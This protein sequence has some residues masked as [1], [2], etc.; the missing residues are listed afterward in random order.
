MVMKATVTLLEKSIDVFKLGS[1][2]GLLWSHGKNVLAGFGDV[3]RLE[4]NSYSGL[5]ESLTFLKSIKP[6]VSSSM[7]PVAFSALP[8]NSSEANAI[9]VPQHCIRQFD[10]GR[11]YVISLTGSFWGEGPPWE[12]LANELLNE[13][14]QDSLDGVGSFSLQIKPSIDPEYWKSK[15]VEKAIAKIKTGELKKVV[16]AREMLVES[17]INF[18]L[19]SILSAL[20]HRN[21][22]SI[23]FLIDGFVGASPEMLISKTGD[24]VT[25]HPLAGTEPRTHDSEQD[26]VLAQQL[27]ES[28]KDQWE[29]RITID[30]FLDTLL[31]FC[32]FV[33]AEPEPTIVELENVFHLGTKVEG[34]LSSESIS[35]C[36]LVQ[37]LHPTPAVG[38]D[39]Q[40][41]A[42]KVIE[43]LEQSPRGRY[44]GPVGW[45]DAS[46]DG[47]FAVGIRSAEIVGKSARL[48]AGVGV[49]ADSDPE[50]ELLETEAK[51]SAMLS[52]LGL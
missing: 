29:H 3:H 11:Q 47:S 24:V 36:E 42:L 37:A 34:F 26:K 32:S 44:A 18:F 14:S 31:P 45:F 19:P 4:S 15:I 23:L 46:G 20:K 41:V 28:T 30:W 51:L 39:P 40:D 16:I 25:A 50:K 8:F 35:V 21:K 38:G 1:A 17:S 5:D 52:S 10:D 27:L 9:F 43:E 6:D 12:S 48:F 33:D 2:S 13:A 7:N 22:N 49:V